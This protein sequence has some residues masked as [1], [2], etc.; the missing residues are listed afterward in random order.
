MIMSVG[1]LL[2]FLPGPIKMY[3][4]TLRRL[5]IGQAE[6][7]NIEVKRDYYLLTDQ[8]INLIYNLIGMY[9]KFRTRLKN[10]DNYV[11]IYIKADIRK[12]ISFKKKKI[13]FRNKKNVVGLDIK[14]DFPKR[15]HIV[16]DNDFNK[17]L[18]ELVK[19]LL[20]KIKKLNLWG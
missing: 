16:I 9:K 1:L 19:E 15:P 14:P 6:K 13:Y 3:F 11:E 4:L 2:D 18:D 17:T 12:I 8:K 7:I 20:S 10:I 5:K